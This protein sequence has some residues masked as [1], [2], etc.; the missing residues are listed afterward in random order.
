[1]MTDLSKLVIGLTGNAERFAAQFNAKLPGAYRQITAQD[2]RAMTDC[3]LIR[4]YG[5]YIHSDL[6]TVRA[7]LQY[8]QILEKRLKK[9]LNE[10]KPIHHAA[11]CVANNYLFSLKVKREDR[12]STVR[13]VSAQDVRTDIGNGG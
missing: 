7:V 2:V 4:R 8:E 6:E 9:P 11:R 13:S 10:E 12:E 1:M 3:G 5:Y